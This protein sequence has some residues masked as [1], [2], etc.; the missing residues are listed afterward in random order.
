MGHTSHQGNLSIGN[1]H[2]VIV[3]L[4]VKD[5]EWLV[6]LRDYYAFFSIKSHAGTG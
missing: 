1:F 2:I 3:M 5:I 4:D 6:W